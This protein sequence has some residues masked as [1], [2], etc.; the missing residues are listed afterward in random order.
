M[1]AV[2]N[3]INLST[4][5][6][7]TD[8]GAG[9]SYVGIMKGVM[10][11]VNPRIRLVDLTHDIPQ[12]DIDAA[13][14]VI[15]QSYSFF[16]RGTIHTIVVDPGVGT[17]RRILAVH[18]D[19][20]YFVAPD[21]GVLKYIY[22]RHPNAQVISLTEP[23]FWL[24]N[25]SHTFHGRDVFAPVA[26]HLA[27]GTA[28]RRLG[29]VTTD[30]ERGNLSKPQKKDKD[31]KGRIEY[32]DGF[33]NCISNI[34]AAMLNLKNVQKVQFKNKNLSDVKNTYGEVKSGEPLVLVGSHNHLE[35]AV[36][37][38]NAAEKFGVTKGDELIVKM[39]S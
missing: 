30:Y 10:L 38:G 23:D 39:T 14:F 8:F 33:G 25:K 13:A 26:A 20:Y 35:I 21:N 1:P 32:I 3:G 24:Q 22:D 16:P 12:G 37:N 15:Y 2:G 6:L 27:M 7:L 9:S 19:D 17:D 34:P 5:A 18:T 29:E 4:I 31:I 36:R 11:S 28:I